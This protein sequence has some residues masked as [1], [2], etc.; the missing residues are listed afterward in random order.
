MG[1][2]R[3]NTTPRTVAE[4]YKKLGIVA[5]VIFEPTKDSQIVIRD[6]VYKMLMKNIRSTGA[7][8]VFPLSQRTRF[9]HTKGTRYEEGAFASTIRSAGDVGKKFYVTA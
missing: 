7:Y 2:W 9:N 3:K 4:V 8:A 1:K 6:M 5:P